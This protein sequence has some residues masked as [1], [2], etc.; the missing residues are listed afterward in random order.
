M[1]DAVHMQSVSE[2][3]SLDHT[4][5]CRGVHVR[6]MRSCSSFFTLLITDFKL[7]FF[8]DRGPHLLLFSDV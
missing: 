7:F 6:K 2:H 4:G 3:S 5:V 1:M 8:F